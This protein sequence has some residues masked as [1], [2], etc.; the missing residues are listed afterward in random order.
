MIFSPADF[1]QRLRTLREDRGFSVRGLA[2]QVGVSSVTVWKWEK[3]E[4]TP[5]ERALGSLADA[6]G[7]RLSELDPRQKTK[8]QP[9]RSVIS[10]SDA[11]KKE[12]DRALQGPPLRSAS[13]QTISATITR[14]KR[15]IAE[16]SGTSVANVTIRI[17]Y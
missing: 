8:S 7:I 15:M 13:R 17:E 3:G 16:A 4:V 1:G 5:R 14:A 2:K 9:A 11:S 12:V 6:L 10:S